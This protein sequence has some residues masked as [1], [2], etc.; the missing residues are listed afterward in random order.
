ML[1]RKALMESIS[2][3]LHSYLK[4]IGNNLSVPNKKF[5]LGIFV[6]AAMATPPDVIS[7]V[8]LALPLYCLFEL[9]ILLS[10]LAE[11]R[12]RAQNNQ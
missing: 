12:K 2:S 6:V 7:Q 1:K 10:Y 8:T 4:K 9:G 5:L 11:Q 3:N